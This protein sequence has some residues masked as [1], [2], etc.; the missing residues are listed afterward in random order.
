[1]WCCIY[2]YFS[3]QENFICSTHLS[4]SFICFGVVPEK[5]QLLCALLLVST[6]HIFPVIL[7]SGKVVSYLSLFLL[8][9]ERTP[10]TYPV[11]RWF[12]FSTLVLLCVTSK[13][14]LNFSVAFLV[15]LKS[16]NIIYFSFISFLCIL[17]SIG[18]SLRLS[19][20][21]HGPPKMTL[22]QSRMLNSFLK[23]FSG[24]CC[25]FLELSFPLSPLESVSGF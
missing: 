11:Y 25:W 15:F 16:S 21:W 3:V 18:L 22:F 20:W 13:V 23:Y 6:L 14:D 1:M 12:T 19:V 10:H 5:Y 9:S 24:F 17:L 4:L 8:H 7:L 2:T